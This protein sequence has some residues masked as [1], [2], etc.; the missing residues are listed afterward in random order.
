MEIDEVVV[1]GGQSG[2]QRWLEMVEV[3]VDNH[4]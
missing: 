2:D 4:Q 1:G 3:V